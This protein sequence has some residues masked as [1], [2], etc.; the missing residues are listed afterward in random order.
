MTYKGQS[1]TTTGTCVGLLSVS[2]VHNIPMEEVVI[3]TELYA[4]AFRETSTTLVPNL[5]EVGQVNSHGLSRKA[6]RLSRSLSQLRDGLK[7]CYDQDM[8]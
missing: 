5:D 1:T 8:I 4:P 7:P 2:E 6:S 3:V